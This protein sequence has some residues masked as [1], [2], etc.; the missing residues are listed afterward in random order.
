MLYTLPSDCLANTPCACSSQDP[1]LWWPRYMSE[2]PGYLYTIQVRS[3]HN[4]SLIKK[5]G[6]SIQSVVEEQVGGRHG[7]RVRCNS[8][9]RLCRFP[10]SLVSNIPERLYLLPSEV[11]CRFCVRLSASALEDSVKASSAL[12]VFDSG[13]SPATAVVVM[14]ADTVPSHF[15]RVVVQGRR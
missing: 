9:H 5:A 1:Q 7:R 4:S 2:R 3:A 8:G 13:V 11:A 12:R 10:C 6:S 14:T 15:Q